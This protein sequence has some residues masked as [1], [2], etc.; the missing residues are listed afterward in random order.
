LQRCAN[1]A[2]YP[3]ILRQM[4]HS[5]VIPMLFAYFGFFFS[6]ICRFYRIYRLGFLDS[7]ALVAESRNQICHFY[8]I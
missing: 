3:S 4:P 2:N 8:Q 5:S 7:G 1:C 6:Q